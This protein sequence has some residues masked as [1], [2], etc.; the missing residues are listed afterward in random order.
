MSLSAFS[1]GFG[2]EI[3]I[4]ILSYSKDTRKISV[5]VENR[6]TDSV[7]YVLYPMLY[8]DEHWIC[9]DYSIEDDIKNTMEVIRNPKHWEVKHVIGINAIKQ[10]KGHIYE[11]L[12]DIHLYYKIEAHYRKKNNSKILN[13]SLK[14]KKKLY[15]FNE[16]GKKIR[17]VGA[18]CRTKE[19]IVVF[20]NIFM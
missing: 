17:L 6:S 8:I 12:I 9:F 5:R 18:N 14:R 10:H 13:E 2:Q 11:S 3:S 15:N 7:C 20:S 16:I 1:Y 19:K 4:D